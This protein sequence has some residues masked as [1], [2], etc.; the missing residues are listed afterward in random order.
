ML[1]LWNESNPNDKKLPRKERPTLKTD[2]TT[3]NPVFFLA[4]QD[5]KPIAYAGYEDNGSFYATAGI[6]VTPE[7]RVG[8]VSYLLNQKRLKVLRQKPSIASVNISVFSKGKWIDHWEEQGWKFNLKDEEIPMEIPMGV[9]KKEINAYGRKNVGVL[10]DR[11]AKWMQ[12]LRKH[13]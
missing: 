2:L 8:G 6:Y 11:L 4:F 10:D 9:Y 7:K 12:V 3:H 13:D 5:D 1:K